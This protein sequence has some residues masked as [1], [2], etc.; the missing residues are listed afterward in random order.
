M[1]VSTMQMTLSVYVRC[2]EKALGEVRWR[3][4]MKTAVGQNAQCS[5]LRNVVDDALQFVH[6]VFFIMPFP[7]HADTTHHHYHYADVL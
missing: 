2:L 1:A 6:C 7:K 3:C 5:L 4:S